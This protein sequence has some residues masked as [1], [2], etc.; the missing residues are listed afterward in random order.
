MKLKVLVEE[1]I[2]QRSLADFQQAGDIDFVPAA[3]EEKALAEQ[4]KSSQSA[5][6]LLA[7]DKYTGP[8][9]DALPEGAL[10]A[11]YGVGHDGVDKAIAAKKQQHVT[12]TPGVLDVSVAEH[13]VF[14]MG[15]L[16][17]N[18]AGT[19]ADIKKGGWLKSSGIELKDKTL[20]ILGC[21]MIGRRTARIASFGFGMNVIGYD[22]AELDAEQMRN[23]YGIG[24]IAASLDEV[25]PVCDFVS[26]HLPSIE[27]TRDFIDADFI[28]KMK[29]SAF[30][31]NT[32]RGGVLDEAAL[33]DALAG[34]KLAGA[35]LDVFKKEPYEP[36][37]PQKDLRKLDNV[38]LASHLASSTLE[39][40][41]R[42]AQC[43]I[44]NIRAWAKKDYNSMNIVTE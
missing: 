3:R 34:G 33:Y 2:Y 37:Q 43:V 38:V 40:S 9:Y 16:A 24:K 17:R 13:A 4:V 35:A 42:M 31:V 25:L 15:A 22:T 36:A 12:I 29:P 5:A 28:S 41:S 10:I 26:V 32:A 19:D 21:G 23:E 6:V 44:K 8:L 39:A 14:L 18:I 7:T 1:G 30:I 27:A 20:L 11:R